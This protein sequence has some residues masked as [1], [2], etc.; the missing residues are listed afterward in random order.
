MQHLDIVRQAAEI[1][2][3]RKAKFVDYLLRFT[4]AKS[5][6]LHYVGA[7]GITDTHV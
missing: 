3:Q 4:V 1:G 6:C 2:A 7:R 5:V